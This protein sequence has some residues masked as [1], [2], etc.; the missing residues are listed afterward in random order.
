M[1]K[2][3]RLSSE[4]SVWGLFNTTPSLEGYERLAA[5]VKSAV[6]NFDFFRASMQPEDKDLTTHGK[7]D[8]LDTWV[9]N[10]GQEVLAEL[11]RDL[12]QRIISVA[13]Y[14][15]PAHDLRQILHKDVCEGLR[16]AEY[17][18]PQG[19]KS[20]FMIPMFCH[21]IG[22]L[23]EG[24]FYDLGLPMSAWIKHSELSYL[25]LREVLDEYPAIPERL[26]NHFL[27]AVLAHSGENGETYMSRAV[28]TCDRMQMLGPEG[29]FRAV[30]FMTGLV[31]NGEIAYPRD[32]RYQTELPILWD[33]KSVVSVMEHVGR[34]MFPNIGESHRDWQQNMMLQNTGLLWQM[35]RASARVRDRIFA[36]ELG[37]VPKTSLG[38]FKRELSTAHMMAVRDM[39]DRTPCVAPTGDEQVPAAMARY[40]CTVLENPYGSAKLTPPMKRNLMTAVARANPEE[41][42]YL[43][44][45]INYAVKGQRQL[46]REDNILVS[47][48]LA[49]P[50]T[51]SLNRVI[52][53]QA[54]QF[55]NSGVIPLNLDA[56]RNQPRFV[57]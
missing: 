52:A 9:L 39:A 56:D 15:L 26:K 42:Y 13:D 47:R 8:E 7:I 28:Q 18:Q 44:V 17:E 25:M 43:A 35:G 33:H 55:A 41:I 3:A 23:L 38:L 50:G 14:A 53:H 34:N 24:K 49:T 10:E 5:R 32:P 51:S 19:Y 6:R 1:N 36:P 48:I 16:F 31:P 40:L 29:F 30:S 22:R 37:H 21:D 11:A 46:D 20:A 57:L 54:Q 27:Y 4:Q 2:P 12:Q 45:G